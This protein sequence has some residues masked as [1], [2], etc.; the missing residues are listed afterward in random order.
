MNSF[1]DIVVW[2]GT[3]AHALRCILPVVFD[4]GIMP[5]VALGRDCLGHSVWDWMQLNA[6]NWEVGTKRPECREHTNKC[7]RNLVKS[8]CREAGLNEEDRLT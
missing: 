7:E 1:S 8:L 6:G 5:A 4:V 3:H 2:W